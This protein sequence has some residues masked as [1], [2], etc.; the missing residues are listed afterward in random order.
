MADRP[1]R[2]LRLLGRTRD[3]SALVM[4]AAGE[5]FVLPVDDSVLSAMGASLPE[6]QG[7][8]QLSPRT[9][10]A[11]IRRGESAAAIAVDSGMELA[12]V[13]RFERPVVAERAH[14]ADLA[15]AT[16][17]RGRPLLDRLLAHRQPGFA[18]G[19]RLAPESPRLDAWLGEDDS[20]WILQAVWPG[21]QVARWQWRP[22]SG[23]LVPTD[24]PA[25]LISEEPAS[26]QDDLE[27]VLRPL[28][29]RPEPTLG[30]AAADPGAVP[31]PSPRNRRASVP[32]WDEITSGR[33][34]PR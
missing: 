12:Y 18:D 24:A 9:I 23:A 33:P 22:G 10:Q 3:G 19:L 30:E 16:I 1:V 6:P 26:R 28:R 27:A 8:E 31:T 15:A 14:Q 34:E 32:S 20:H 7:Q 29:S 4:E 2:Q 5:R 11:R 13:A 17:V 21:G 25:R